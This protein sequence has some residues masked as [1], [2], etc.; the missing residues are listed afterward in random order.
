MNWLAHDG[1]AVVAYLLSYFF[2]ADAAATGVREAFVG[3][4]GYDRRGAGAVWADCC[5][6]RRFAPGAPA[7][8]GRR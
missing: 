4:S 6:P 7:T 8:T 5:S 3:H 1:E 2:E